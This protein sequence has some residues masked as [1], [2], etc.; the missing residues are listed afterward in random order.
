MNSWNGACA[1]SRLGLFG[2]R[3]RH[4]QSLRHCCPNAAGMIEVMMRVDGLREGLARSQ[5]P[6]FG[7]DRKS[8]VVVLR[9]LDERQMI[10]KLDRHAVVSAA[11][12]PDPFSELRHRHRGC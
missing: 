6:G 7:D 9:R 5:L 3:S 10:V 4:P 8:A 1:S 11:E 2:H 12:Q